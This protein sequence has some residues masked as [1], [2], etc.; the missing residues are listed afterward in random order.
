M[1]ALRSANA[2]FTGPP[3]K[4]TSTPMNSTM[5]AI[6]RIQPGMPK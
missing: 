4:Y 5:L 6:F 3:T 2:F 1:A